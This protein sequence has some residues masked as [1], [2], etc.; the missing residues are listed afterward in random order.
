MSVEVETDGI[1]PPAELPR[2]L[3]SAL[4]E[5]LKAYDYAADV[6]RDPWDF[7]I[8]MSQLH[9]MHMTESDARW[10]ICRGY[11]IQGTEI[12]RPE[13]VSR[14]IRRSENLYLSKR[15]CLVLTDLGASL[16]RTLSKGNSQPGKVP[17]EVT[18]DF[19]PENCGVP[20]WER[21]RHELHWNGMLVKRFKCVALN[22]ETILSV[23]QEEGWPPRIDDPL[24][25]HDD[26]DNKRRLHDTIKCLNRN[27]KHRLLHFRGDGSGE[28]VLWEPVAPNSNM[29]RGG[30]VLGR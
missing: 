27:Q 7:A 23:F 15:A 3:Y 28:G 21:D 29:S 6:H 11:A 24:P 18:I 30:T 10:L 5:L 1:S 2:Q 12:T 26:L 19:C 14:T 4:A 8:S 25:P 20:Q 13:D 9:S 17:C 16:I 22:Q